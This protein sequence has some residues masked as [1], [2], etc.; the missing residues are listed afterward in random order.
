MYIYFKP[1]YERVIE[2][3]TLQVVMNTQILEFLIEG[4]LSLENK[5]YIKE[6]HPTI[7]SDT[8]KSNKLL[9]MGFILLLGGILL[10]IFRG[11]RQG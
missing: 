9:N 1:D 8:K 2:K 7:L 4:I 3:A 10:Y 6:N 5:D 11:M